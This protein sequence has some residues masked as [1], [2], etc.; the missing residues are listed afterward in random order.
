MDLQY[1]AT[2]GAV[3]PTQRERGY[4]TRRCH[5]GVTGWVYSTYRCGGAVLSTQSS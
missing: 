2:V 5:G 1:Q 3:L 4:S